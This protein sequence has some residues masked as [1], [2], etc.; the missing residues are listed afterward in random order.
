GG[1]GNKMLEPPKKAELPG[2]EKLTVPAMKPPT[3]Q[4]TEKPEEA[5]PNQTLNIP[6]RTLGTEMTTAPGTIESP[7]TPN[8]ESQGAGSGGGAGDGNGTGIGSGEGSG[9]GSGFG[10]G[11]GGGAYRPGSG[12]SITQ[13][14]REVRP[15]YTADAMRAKVQGA[16]LLECIVLPD[17]SVGQIKILKSLDKVFGL[18]D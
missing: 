10:G 11:T 9:F 5:K 13:L 7:P 4:V 12:V 6:A 3:P 16:V 14:V 8:P 18:D 2:K 1:G 17:G 15:E